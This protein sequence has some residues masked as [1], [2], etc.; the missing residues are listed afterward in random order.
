MLLSGGYWKGNIRALENLAEMRCHSCS[1][2]T[3]D[4]LDPVESPA[5][6]ASLLEGVTSSLL[7]GLT[8]LTFISD[9]TVGANP[10][11]PHLPKKVEPPHFKDRKSESQK[12]EEDLDADIAR[13]L[14]EEE[15]DHNADK[16]PF[17]MPVQ[18]PA[19]MPDPGPSQEEASLTGEEK[20]G[21]RAT[22]PKD[23]PS[24]KGSPTKENKGSELHLFC[25][26]SVQLSAL[27][28][29]S[30]LMGCPRLLE[31]LLVPT[32]SPEEEASELQ[33]T[34]RSVIQQMVKR[35]VLPSPIKRALSLSELERAF[36]VLYQSAVCYWAEERLGLRAKM[37]Q[38][39][40]A[41]LECFA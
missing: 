10:L 29:L 3:L 16:K 31:Q 41:S 15:S 11:F 34:V 37:G 19:A 14:G 2:A 21:Q 22:R 33:A 17:I 7:H 40:S 12:L 1:D 38:S 32:A 24:P 35:A 39:C 9:E 23:W 28:A 20:E 13:A 6:D 5:F 30:V 4:S 26:A 27:K 36:G 18:G 8:Q 25:L